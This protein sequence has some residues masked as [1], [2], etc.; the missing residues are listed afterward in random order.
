MKERAEGRGPRA[1]GDATSRHASS[2]APRVL[3]LGIGN[4]LWADEGFGVRCVEAMAA[5]VSVRCERQAAR[6]RHPGHL[7]GGPGARGGCLG[8]VR[9]RRLRPAR[10]H[11][12]ARRRG[13]GAQVHGGE[14][15]EPASDRLPGGAGDGRSARRLS[16]ASVADRRAA[17]RV[18]GL[19]RQPAAGGQGA[20]RSRHR[21]G[22]GVS[23]RTRCRCRC[24]MRRSEP[25][26]ADLS[27]TTPH[28]ALDLAAYESGRPSPELA[29]R[30]GD[31]RLL[32]RLATAEAGS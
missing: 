1:E 22:A 18:G 15:D 28:P 2:P 17:G 31:E 27:P 4:I 19:R 24:R 26:V 13:C 30:I 8:G 16:G 9:R 25:P 32:S 11:L 14:E 6:W 3:V 23:G 10:W 20:D 12:E 7:S 21:P 29:C 5:G